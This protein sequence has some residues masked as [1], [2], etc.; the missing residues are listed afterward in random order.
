MDR[1]LKNWIAEEK[2]PKVIVYSTLPMI[3]AILALFAYDLLESSLLAFNGED[4]LTAL[5]FTLP[6]TT[7]VT[8]IAIG[9]SIITNNKIVKVSCLQGHQLSNAISSS[10]LQATFF[11]A[12]FSLVFCFFNEAI[13][14]FLG[15]RT[16]ASGHIGDP[17][18][19]LANSQMLYV[20]SRYFTWIFLAI[21]WQVSAIFRALGNSKM[22]SRLMLSWLLSKSVMAIALLIPESRFYISGLEGLAWTHGITDVLFACISLFILDKKVHLTIPKLA[23]IKGGLLSNKLNSITIV[24]QQ[25]VAPISMAIITTI[26]VE[27]NYSYVAAFA[28]IFRMESIFLLIPMVLTTTMPCIVGTNFWLGHVS[29]V[30]QAYLFAFGLVILLQLVLALALVIN[31]NMLSYFICPEGAVAEL[32]TLYLTWVPFGYIGAGLV[33]VYQSCLNAEGRPWQA[34]SLGVIHRII[35]LLPCTFI[36]AVFLT[37][38]SLFQALMLGHLAGGIYV[39]YIFYR[40]NKLAKATSTN[41]QMNNHLSHQQSNTLGEQS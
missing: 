16:W 35:L 5:G 15:S 1:Q 17:K 3:T 14:S 26:V 8:A 28:F 38:I 6:I 36:G 27:I 34:L 22:A 2:I 30:R 29:R 21:I 19:I 31:N 4:V 33:I 9:M 41:R 37:E 24:S 7:A 12:L 18:I 23:E 40:R 39:V 10:L 32:L 11:I 25:L 13:F 20:E